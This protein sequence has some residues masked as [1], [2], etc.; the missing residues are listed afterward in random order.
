MIKSPPSSPL[1]AYR[2]DY[3]TPSFF[4]TSLPKLKAH[5]SPNGAGTHKE[6][7]WP[8]FSDDS[9]VITDESAVIRSRKEELQLLQG[10]VH[11]LEVST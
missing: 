8:R 11:G 10:V 1:D 3:G 7:K 5:F 6:P 2:Q 9:N 4:L